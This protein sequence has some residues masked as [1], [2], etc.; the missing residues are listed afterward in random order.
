MDYGFRLVLDR[1]AT[2]TGYNVGIDKLN[3]HLETKRVVD[4]TIPLQEAGP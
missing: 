1:L 4:G 3:R 2:P